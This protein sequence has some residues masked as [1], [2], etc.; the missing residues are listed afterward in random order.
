MPAPA[1]RFERPIAGDSYE[2]VARDDAMQRMLAGIIPEWVRG[3]VFLENLNA[4][5]GERDGFL[6]DTASAAT[7]VAHGLGRA[8]RGWIWGRVRQNT[9]GT[10]VEPEVIEMADDDALWITGFEDT[11]IQLRAGAALVAFRGWIIAF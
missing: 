2:Q 1:Q 6:F 9:T 5:T 3:S 4:T 11:H 10:A 7:Y 8:H